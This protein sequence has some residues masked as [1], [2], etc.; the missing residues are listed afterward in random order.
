MTN[1]VTAQ[2]FAGTDTLPYVLVAAIIFLLILMPTAKQM[3][4]K[5]RV[6]AAPQA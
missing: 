4:G 1:V 3:G 6:P 5:E 2:N